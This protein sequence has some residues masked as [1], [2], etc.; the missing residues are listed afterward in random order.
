MLHFRFHNN[1]QT[2]REN[3]SHYGKMPSIIAIVSLLRSQPENLFHLQI[4]YPKVKKQK[5]TYAF[6][7]R[8]SSGTSS[9]SIGFNCLEFFSK[10]RICFSNF[11]L[12]RSSRCLMTAGSSFFF[13]F[14]GSAKSIGVVLIALELSSLTVF[15][16]RALKRHPFKLLMFA[17]FILLTWKKDSI[18]WTFYFPSCCFFSTFF[19]WTAIL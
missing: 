12:L 13:F 6:S 1:L 10:R 17:L 19:C 16:A 8:S 7:S 14:N 3:T 2:Y 4:I 9:S 11:F 5:Q 18:A 15:L